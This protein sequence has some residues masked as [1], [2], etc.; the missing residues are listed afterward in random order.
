MI[1]AYINDFEAF[2]D[3]MYSKG[4]TP[5]KGKRKNLK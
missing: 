5:K 1:R 2:F 3:A 4:L